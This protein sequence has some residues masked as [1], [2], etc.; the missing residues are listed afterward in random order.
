MTLRAVCALLSALVALAMASPTRALAAPK[1]KPDLSQAASAILID[2]R[3]GSVIVAKDPRERRPMAS[4]TKLMTALLTLERTK[5]DQVLTAS[6]Y[7]PAAAES[8]INLR[9]GERM[10][11]SDLFEGMMLESANDAAETLA[12]GISGSRSQFVLAMNAHARA[13]GLRDTSYGNPIG[14]DDPATRTSARDLATLARRLM[15]NP[16]FASVVGRP[17]AVLETGARR[18]VVSN[19]NDLV[20]RY[21]YVK[22]VKTGHTRQAGYVLVGAARNAV[23]AKVIS[24]VMGEPGEAAR[25]ADSL[26]LLQYG[27]TRF[28]RRKVLDADV[29][30]ASAKVEYRD[31]RARLVPATDRLV[32]VQRGE[33]V[34]RRIDA[35]NQLGETPA[36]RR[37]G[38]I[39]VLLHGK[40][41][42]RVPLVT[43]AAVPGAGPLRIVVHELGP[44]LT[45]FLTLLV[46]CAIVLLVTRGR[47]RRRERALAERRRARDRSRAHTEG[48]SE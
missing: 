41:V 12:E 7:R 37:V 11:V 36:G 44:A 25:N 14:L 47:S 43:V 21:P 33:K 48:A 2:S 24:V 23:G 35:P 13:L 6:D 28:T 15:A 30:V 39:A 5:P 16:R 32:L 26:A 4:T 27:L 31:Q 29:P 9:P 8:K 3:D 20:G 10:R 22:G 42:Q 19:R 38:T 18:R 46:V 1:Q 40:V 45:I 17:M 34:R